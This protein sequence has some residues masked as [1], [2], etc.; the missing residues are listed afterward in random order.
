MSGALPHHS[1]TLYVAG[2]T[3][4]DDRYEDVLFEA[5]CGDALIGVLGEEMY[6]DFDR[7]APSF[8]EAVKS[9]VQNV[10]KAGGKVIKIE[11]IFD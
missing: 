5:G 1:F 11:R 9:A 10:E 7:A 8:E 4:E 2:I 6:L 3:T